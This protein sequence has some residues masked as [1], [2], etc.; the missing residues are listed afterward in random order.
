MYFWCFAHA[1]D[2]AVHNPQVDVSTA[3]Q[4][5]C[6]IRLVPRMKRTEACCYIFWSFSR[7]AAQAMHS[8]QVAISTAHQRACWIR[9]VTTKKWTEACR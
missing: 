7:G 2:E 1:G 4:R 6:W 9:L 5:A 8:P 3:H